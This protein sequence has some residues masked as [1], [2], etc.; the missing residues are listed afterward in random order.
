MRARPY[1]YRN[2]YIPSVIQQCYIFRDTCGNQESQLL[3]SIK[4]VTTSND[5]L[6]AHINRLSQELTKKDTKIEELIASN[7]QLTQEVEECKET[8]K[9]FNT[10]SDQ[11]SSGPKFVVDNESAKKHLLGL[12]LGYHLSLIHI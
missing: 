11:T 1:K 8:D 6:N 3:T 9:R 12:G 10:P 7:F 5:S 4:N 2:K